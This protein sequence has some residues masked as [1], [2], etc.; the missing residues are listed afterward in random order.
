MKGQVMTATDSTPLY[1]IS[2]EPGAATFIRMEDSTALDWQTI[3][4]DHK[5]LAEGTADNVLG[6]LRGI[7]TA[8]GGFAVDRL[9]HSL[10][11]AYRAELD[12]KDEKYLMCCLL[13]DI[14]DLLAPDN[15][16]DIAAAIVKPFVSEAY[17]WMVQ[18]HGIFQGYYFWHHLGGDRNARDVFK[19][20]EYYDLC[21]EFTA[22]YDM[23]AFD[24]DYATPPLEY[25]E[26]MLRSFFA[27]EL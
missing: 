14:G 8:A 4:V 20:H 2:S 19:G 6:Q 24:P 5:K 18:Q 26:P 13:H 11:T 7:E 10:Q 16:P 1:T 3:M 27:R 23:P 17:H 15:H 12:G 21:D 9:F 25:Y 22:K